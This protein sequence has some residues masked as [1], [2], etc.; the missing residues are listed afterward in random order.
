[1]VISVLRL[2][3]IFCNIWE[4]KKKEVGCDMSHLKKIISVI[5]SFFT[6]ILLLILIMVIYGKCSMMFTDRVYPSYFGYTMF[7]VAS[8]SMAPTLHVDDVI[9]VNIT[10][11]NLKKGDIIAFQNDN[12]VITHRILLID[13]DTI[14]VK[15]DSNN[16]IDKP[17]NR[18]QVI[19]KVIKVF[20]KMGV[21][22]KII[23]EPKTLFAI[24]ITLV[25]FD[26]ALSYNKENKTIEKKLDDAFAFNDSGKKQV[27]KDILR[28]EK[29]VKKNV[30][31][32]GKEIKRDVIESE[33][34]LEITRK[35]DIEEINR[36]LEDEKIRLSKKEI[37]NI[38][39]ELDST[40]KK[41]VHSVNLSEKEKKF[42]EYTMRLDLNEIQK[43]IAKKVK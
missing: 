6:Y 10:K 3:Q 39:K 24:F 40:S 28:K 18:N 14:T 9:L 5:V 8:G 31:E 25:L 7:E 21:W 1:M 33:K 4:N 27:K 15:G 12:V 41:E 32:D 30:L 16:T 29:L 38:N 19:G 23:T 43:K 13:N 37:N 34:L 26:F 35:I 2:V 11:N 36:L 17:I 42:L 22:K 20:P